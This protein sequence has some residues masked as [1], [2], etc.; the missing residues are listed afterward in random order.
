MTLLCCLKIQADRVYS[1]A[2]NKG[3]SKCIP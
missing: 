3:D 2:V 1:R